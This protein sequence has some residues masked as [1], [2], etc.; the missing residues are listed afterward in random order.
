[1]KQWWDSYLFRGSPSFILVSKLKALKTNLK[2]WNDEVFCN[3]ERKKKL[4][5][6]ELHVFYVL[7]ERRALSTEEEMKKAKIVSELN[8]ST[9][10]EEVSW[11]NKSR[12]LCLREGDKST[13]FFNI[14]A[15][16]NRKRKTIDLFLIDG[17]I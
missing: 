12:V 1:M 16:S 7:E 8:R 10:M 2:R 13:K 6:E 3:V 9:L 5:L 15:N 17:T 4:L 11:K 14:L